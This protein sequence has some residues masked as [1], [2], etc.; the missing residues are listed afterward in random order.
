MYRLQAKGERSMKIDRAASIAWL[1]I[2]VSPIVIFYTGI[3]QYGVFCILPL[4]LLAVF[5]R[6]IWPIR[7]EGLWDSIGVQLD[8]AIAFLMIGSFVFGL[9]LWQQDWY[10]MVR[11]LGIG[12]LLLIVGVGLLV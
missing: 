5:G 6:N 8:T 11:G 2:A 7:L 1:I 10:W 3:I 4:V 12:G 9:G